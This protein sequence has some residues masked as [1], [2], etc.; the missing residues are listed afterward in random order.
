MRVTSAAT[1]LGTTGFTCSYHS[2]VPG[3]G[4]VNLIGEKYANSLGTSHEVVTFDFTTGVDGG[5]SWDDVTPG[6]RVYLSLKATS[7]LASINALA[8]TS[9]WEW[10]YNA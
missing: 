2:A 9:L 1:G 10:D 7:S 5:T 4:T 6:S 3:T 8:V